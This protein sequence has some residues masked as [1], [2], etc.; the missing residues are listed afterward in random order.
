[1]FNAS[2]GTMLAAGVLGCL[3]AWSAW[4]PDTY[5]I[6]GR[7]VDRHRLWRDGAVLMLVQRE[8]T[9]PHGGSHSYSPIDLGRNGSF[10]TRP[11]PPGV[12]VVEI[13]KSRRSRDDP[14]GIIGLEVVD[15]GASDVSNV[16][17]EVRR[18][19][20]IE[21][22]FRMESDNPNAVWPAVSVG[23]Y[24]ALRGQALGVRTS[25]EPKNDGT[26]ELRN[27]FGPRVVR[28]G[29]VPAPGH[30]W[31]PSYVRL[32]GRDITNVPTE[33]SEHPNSRLEIVFTQR[34]ARIT[35]VVTIAGGQA[36]RAP[37]I[38]TSSADASLHQEWATTNDVNQADTQGRFSIP[39]LPGSY[40]IRA[41]PQA[42]FDSFQSAR[43]EILRRAPAGVTVDI[44]KDREIQTINLTLR[45]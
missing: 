13:W 24:L 8:E 14:G 26:F 7:I 9:I 2:A 33:F 36:A 43:R 40:S 22:R 25:A 30:N 21:G 1:M 45:P 27:A 38:F 35:G 41:V 19:F 23:T 18:D 12:Y 11:V 16:E 32:D 28:C 42:M 34:P 31:W 4:Q 17:V 39:V 10:V 5:L 37:W 20:R 15:V 3:A 29:W 6:S 44:V